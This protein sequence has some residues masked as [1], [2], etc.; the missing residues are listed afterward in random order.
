MLSDNSAPNVGGSPSFVCGDDKRRLLADT[1]VLLNIHQDAT[2][3]FD[4]FG[5]PKRRTA[6]PS[7]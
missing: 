4:G 3:Y 5:S 2:P 1:T 6:A 7:C